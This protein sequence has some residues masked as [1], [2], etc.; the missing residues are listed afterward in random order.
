MNWFEGHNAERCL[1]VDI[2]EPGI[3]YMRDELN[4]EDVIASDVLEA[5][6][7]EPG[8][9]KDM[10]DLM[11]V[12]EVLEHVDN[13]VSF[14][15]SL[16]QQQ[17]G[18]VRTLLVSV[19]NAF[20][21]ENRRFSRGGIEMINSDHRY[22]FTPYTISKVLDRAGLRPSRLILCRNGKVKPR[23]VLRN[24][25]RRRYPLIRDTLISVSDFPQKPS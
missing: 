23:A 22:W 12:A 14:L 25:I 4:Y 20:A 18:K 7:P 5:D 21:S 3:Q 1:G 9:G 16:A 19:P 11:I 17:A 13:P 10:W 15:S 6:L 24:A 8:G 2:D